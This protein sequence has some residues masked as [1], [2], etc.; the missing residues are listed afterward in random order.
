MLS[1][2]R[3]WLEILETSPVTSP[4]ISPTNTVD[5]I[6]VAPVTTPASTTI[7]PSNTICCPLS[8]VISKSVPAVDEIVLP[9]RLMLSTCN[10][11][12]VPTE[13]IAV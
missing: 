2:S 4:V 10:A 7:A 1:S 9:L 12:R 5:V 11:V 3:K 6:L 8:G 13:V